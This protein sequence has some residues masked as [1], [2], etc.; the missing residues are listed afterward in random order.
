[1]PRT[2]CENC[3]KDKI[4]YRAYLEGEGQAGILRL[5]KDKI[6]VC[7]KCAQ[8]LVKGGWIFNLRRILRLD[9]G[10]ASKSRHEQLRDDLDDF[11]F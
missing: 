5:T 7:Q 1:L 3:C 11:G 6:E 9:L 2:T 4:V 8:K 10:T